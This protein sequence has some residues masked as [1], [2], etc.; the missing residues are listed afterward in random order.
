MSQPSSSSESRSPEINVRPNFLDDDYSVTFDDWVRKFGVSVLDE[1]IDVR[2]TFFDNEGVERYS[3]TWQIVSRRR[4]AKVAVACNRSKLNE[5][6]LVKLAIRTSPL[7][8]IDNTNIAKSAAAKAQSTNDST[9]PEIFFV[10]YLLNFRTIWE[11][12]EADPTDEF[13]ENAPLFY[14]YLQLVF[15]RRTTIYYV[16]AAVYYIGMELAMDLIFPTAANIT[17]TNT[18]IS[19][20]QDALPEAIE[21][22][23]Y[24]RLVAMFQGSLTSHLQGDKSL[25]KKDT[26]MG[27]VV[28]DANKIK[29]TTEFAS[30]GN[31]DGKLDYRNRA[32]RHNRPVEWTYFMKESVR[33]TVREVKFVFNRNKVSH[34]AASIKS[35]ESINYYAAMNSALKFIRQHN[36]L[37]GERLLN[38]PIYRAALLFIGVA[39][40]LYTFITT[41]ISPLSNL[42]QSLKV[43]R[44]IGWDTAVCQNLW[45]KTRLT[46]YLLLVFVSKTIIIQAVLLALLSLSFGSEIAHSLIDSWIVR[47][48]GLRRLVSG[49]A[50]SDMNPNIDTSGGSNSNSASNNNSGGTSSSDAA[51]GGGGGYYESTKE[52][53]L[54][55]DAVVVSALHK[56][57]ALDGKTR[58]Q[59]IKEYNDMK[60]VS[61]TPVES[62]SYL[63]RDAFEHYLFLNKFMSIASRSWSPLIISFYFL[64]VFLCFLFVYG[65]VEYINLI[66]NI[67]LAYYM[68]YMAIRTYIMVI[69][70][71]AAIAGANTL[72]YAMKEQFLVAAPEDF[73]VLGGRDTW[74]SYIDNVPVY[75]TLYGLAVT[76]DRL[77]ALVWTIASTLGFIALTIST[78]NSVDR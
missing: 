51:V 17:V 12:F 13:V 64:Y 66:S 59:F 21:L 4:R 34:N 45:W 47:F 50:T 57:P 49:H 55:P 16:I 62:T 69:Y 73:G 65:A 9:P 32:Y 74:L 27:G 54:V 38:R 52:P 70:P 33:S 46:G 36:P 6:G 35:G 28:E 53:N 67:E 29:V 14:T 2:E 22:Y 72:T 71:I 23:I 25:K 76:W 56:F 20:I 3:D 61:I 58:K 11:Y 39:V 77:T 48:S 60:A 40:P 78:G 8:G 63:Q 41:Y 24:L 1:I 75:W 44:V 30:T 26:D 15:H 10:S 68:I 42:Q 7:I 37:R 5:T 18:A 19:C 31:K 43:C